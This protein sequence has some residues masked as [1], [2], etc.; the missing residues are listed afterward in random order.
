MSRIENTVHI[1]I[2]N[3]RAFLSGAESW[4]DPDL[5]REAAEAVAEF[6]HLIDEDDLVKAFQIAEDLHVRWGGDQHG[7]PALNDMRRLVQ[8]IGQTF[9]YRFNRAEVVGLSTRGVFV[10]WNGAP[11]DDLLVWGNVMLTEGTFRT[12]L[13]HNPQPESCSIVEVIPSHYRGYPG[14]SMCACRYVVP[15]RIAGQIMFDNDPETKVL[16][17]Y[18]R[19]DSFAQYTFD[20]SGEKVRD[21]WPC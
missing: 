5:I 14:A 1:I 8:T 4:E 13:P 21:N 2:N 11:E 9:E 20:Y 6:D 12:L 7:Q 15:D 10:R 19:E 16:R 3:L 17:P 18:R